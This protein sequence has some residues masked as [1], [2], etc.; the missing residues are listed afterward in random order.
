MHKC[1]RV[2][3]A[4]LLAQVDYTRS[5]RGNRNTTTRRP[6]AVTPPVLQERWAD[7]RLSVHADARIQ[8]SDMQWVVFQQQLCFLRVFD[9]VV[10]AACCRVEAMGGASSSR[11]LLQAVRAAKAAAP[12]VHAAPDALQLPARPHGAIDTLRSAAPAP[13]ARRAS[14]MAISSV[15]ND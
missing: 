9:R 2:F 3:F 10:D 7:G 8:L 11:A 4:H 14:A 5:G 6:P 13:V 1:D 15:I 12:G